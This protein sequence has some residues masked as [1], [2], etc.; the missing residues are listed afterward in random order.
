MDW[1]EV[2]SARSPLIRFLSLVRPYRRLVV[3]AALMGVGKFTLPLAFPL[4]F[5]YIIDV[6]LASRP[7]L[8]RID[9]VIDHCCA[10]LTRLA[11]MT[12]D[13]E[14]KL[15]ALSAALLLLYALQS[16]ASYYRNYWA[17]VAG[18]RLIFDLQSK[19]FAHL[20]RL[21]HAFFDH[22]PSGAIVSRVLNDV[23]QA[24]ELVNSALI[25]V[26]MDAASLGLVV[27]VLFVMDWRL[28]LV[29]LC[30]APVWVTFMRYFS[31]RIKAVSHR[32]QETL[33][34]ISGEVHERVA[35]AST[36][37]SFGRE[38]H[39]V[40]QFMEHT[41]RLYERTIDKVRLAA[42]QEML[43]Q[44]LTRC[45]PTIVVWVGALMIIRGTMTLGTMVAFF[46]YL[47]FLYLPLERFA[48]FSVV[49]SGSLAAIERMFEFLDIKPEITDHPLSRPFAVR[50]G[51][52]QFDRVSFGYAA[53][54]GAPGREVLT[55][56]NL[57]IPG[58]CKVA[59]VGRSGAGKT[60]LASLIPR[61]YDVSAGRVLIDGKDVRHHTLKSLRDSV[62]LV[63]QD[64]L[65]FSASIRDNLLYARPDASGEMLWQALALA[66][67]REWVEKLP[68]GIETVI[69]ERGVKVSGGQRQRLAL[70]RAFLKDSKIVILDEATSAIDSESENLI[71]EA[72]ERL[73]EGRT[74]FLIAH[75]LRSAISADL[76]V[77]LDQGTIVE[78]G[79][80]PQLLSRGG[81]YA[82]LFREQV[83]GLALE[84]ALAAHGARSNMQ[85]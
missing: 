40:H 65:L 48:Q 33:E 59:L 74:V 60:T 18:N 71:H 79:T 53:R 24:H 15:A 83:R 6:L 61:F 32:M 85:A 7:K 73:M 11:G 14:H 41:E 46:T 36:I 13:V 22:N 49:V 30:I 78:I 81:T 8:D 21:P 25:D 58:G 35:G 37:K 63:A 82:R 72:I 64:A 55:D 1:N 80:H 84:P 31:P 50:R 4:A 27:M 34:N 19:L 42:R 76:I 56:L 57:S 20:Q 39:E 28:A 70:A 26:W 16:V 29:A 9:L 75:R 12:P 66:N 68:A 45:A 52:V 17:G 51:A 77:V 67:M 47:G 10:G 3:G 5:K 38:D 23:Q 62:S 2:E 69:G 54:D 44:L 43:I